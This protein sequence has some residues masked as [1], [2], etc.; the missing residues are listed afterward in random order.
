MVAADPSTLPLAGRRVLR[1]QLPGPGRPFDPRRDL[2]VLRAEGVRWIVIGGSVT[3][4]VLAA[5]ASYPREARFYRAL[6]RM[7][8]AYAT[9]EQPERRDRPWL[10]VYRVYS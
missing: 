4:R 9:G 7:R 3:D 10:R 8:P 6:E 1:L 2:E 5:P